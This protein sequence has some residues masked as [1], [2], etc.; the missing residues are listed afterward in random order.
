MYNNKT[1]RHGLFYPILFFFIE[2]KI[3]IN[4]LSWCLLFKF[5]YNGLIY[6]TLTFKKGLPIRKISLIIYIY[7]YINRKRTHVRIYL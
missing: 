6:P 2:I 5:S 1:K 3:I 4:D 7:K